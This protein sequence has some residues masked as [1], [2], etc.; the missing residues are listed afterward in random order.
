MPQEM[1]K[2]NNIHQLN[3]PHQLSKPYIKNNSIYLI[4][5]SIFMLI[6]V[7][8]FITRAIQYRKSNFSVIFA[9]ACGELL[10]ASKK[11]FKRAFFLLGQ[12]LN[13]DCAF[14]LVL[15]LRQTLTYLRT[16]GLGAIFPLDQ[17]IYLHKLT[18]W[19]IVS[20]GSFHTV[21]H[22]INF[23]KIYCTINGVNLTSTFKHFNSW[24]INFLQLLR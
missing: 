11:I 15:M 1:M 20:L 18:G 16:R 9:R 10:K 13:F 12:C 17:H 21:M 7:T 8:L 19:M 3:L 24:S 23:S 6:N 14:V 4:F 2:K 5:V 22:V